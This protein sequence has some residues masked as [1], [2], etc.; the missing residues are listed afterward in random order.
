PVRPH[1]VGRRGRRVDAG[2]VAVGPD[3]EGPGAGRGGQGRGRRPADPL[4]PGDGR[5]RG[6]AVGGLVGGG[7]GRPPPPRQWDR[8][9][10]VAGRGGLPPRPGAGV[11]EV[12]HGSAPL[13][14]RGEDDLA[15]LRVED[16]DDVA[17]LPVGLHRVGEVPLGPEGV[18]RV[19]GRRHL[20]RVVRV[21]LSGICVPGARWTPELNGWIVREAISLFGADRCMWASNFPVDGLVADYA[22]ILNAMFVITQHLSS[23]DRARIFSGTAAEVYRL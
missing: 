15:G 3:P 18:E 14:R 8:R 23:A 13:E 2:R 11:D 5:P 6:D 9:V 1:V 21:K 19:P 16:D 7:G 20:V 4:V 17:L 22:D 10:R 12:G